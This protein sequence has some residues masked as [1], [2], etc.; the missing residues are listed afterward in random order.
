M[1]SRRATES[2]APAGPV[3]G[4]ACHLRHASAWESDAPRTAG[5]QVLAVLLTGGLLAPPG[6]FATVAVSPRGAVATASRDASEIAAAMLRRGGNAFD[7][8]VSAAFAIGV[9]QPY[10]SGLGGGGFIVGYL[11]ESRRVVVLDFREVAPAGATET[12]FLRDGKPVPELSHDGALAIAVPG[13]ALGY[14]E[15][16]RRLGRRPLKELVEPAARLADAG[17]LVTPDYRDQAEWRAACLAKDPDATAI[18]LVKD[19]QRHAAPPLRARIV[20]RD[21]ARTL[22]A[23]AADGGRSFYQGATARAIADDVRRKGGILAATDLTAYAVRERPPLWGSFRGH[24][25]A[26]MPPPSAGGVTVLALLGAFDA[27]EPGAY[28]TPEELHRFAEAAKIV[29][30]DRAAL[31]G[32]PAFSEVPLEAFGA[33]AYARSV[34]ERIDPRRAVPSTEVRPGGAS[35]VAPA[36]DGGHTTHIS[37]I[38]AAGN[39]ASLT[40]TV[41]DGFG[42]CVVAR[43]SGVLLNNQMD[44]FAQAPGVPNAYGLVTGKANTVAPGKVP[45]SSMS[46]TLVFQKER[47]DAVYVAIGSPGGPRIP[48]A[49]ALA[50][51]NL[52]DHRMPLDRAIAAAR[53]HH[54]YL[55]DALWIEPPGLEAATIE[56]LERLGHHIEIRPE[57][58]SNVQA[59]MV[60]PVTGLRIAASDYRREGVA[61]GVER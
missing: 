11:A 30:A 8:A 6:A 39:A 31:F 28:R 59:V 61:R 53:I 7:A 41:N 24:R 19:G 16:A 14:V 43:G 50:L 33:P 21:L 5:R 10:D 36:R 60:D 4:E 49:V 54:Q 25:I 35:A 56:A 52:V 22:R 15:I 3:G 51:V 34:R 20:Q 27:A 29:Y 55:P 47:P 38:D 48:T 2:F 13:A 23:L 40:T 17:V 44:D 57:P 37:V 46:P 32:D 12:M 42:S 1:G 58:W 26:T 18:F 9:A 45:L